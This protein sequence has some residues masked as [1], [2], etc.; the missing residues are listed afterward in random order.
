[1]NR[2]TPFR[3]LA[4]VVVLLLMAVLL[5]SQ[6][7]W[8][9]PQE[10]VPSVSVQ[11][12]DVICD[13]QD[14]SC[15]SK[16]ESSGA[17][18]WGYVP[19]G[20]V[21]SSGAYNL[22]AYWTYNGLNS[23]IDWGLWTPNLPQTGTYDVYIWYPHYPGIVP[24]TNSAR[25]QVHDTGG[26]QAIT[27]NQA[28]N[29]GQWNKIA[30]VNCTAGTGCFVKLTDATSESTSTR[31]VWFDAVKFVLT[32]TPVYSITGVVRDS[33]GTGISDV[34]I[35]DGTR[36]ATTDSSGS[37]TL[38][39]VPVGNYTL[40]PM[41][42][43]Y[44]FSPITLNVTVASAVSGQNFTGT[45]LP[46]SSDT[47]PPDGSITAPL[48]GQT[49]DTSALTFSAVASD[50]PGGSGVARVQF[51]VYYNG[52]WHNVGSATTSPY[53]VRWTPPVGLA[54]QQLQFAIHVFDH[55]GNQRI[56]PG[57]IRL[58]N[59][60]AN[61]A[62]DNG[63]KLPYP[64][65]A[66]WLCTQGNN[67]N[68]SH[69]GQWAYAFDF[70]TPRGSDV[71]ASRNG[72][73]IYV[74]GDSTRGGCSESY[75]NDAN[76]I[77]I[78]H[79]DGTDT[80]YVHLDSVFVRNG[81]TVQRGQ[82]IGR[83]GQ[84][85]YTC[86]N[87]GGP[88]PHLHFDRR[89]TGR[90]STIAT[91]FLDVVGGVP[92]AG[93]WYTSGN[94]VGLASDSV[95]PIGEVRFR[96]TGSTPYTISLLAEDDTTPLNALEMRLAESEAGLASATWQPF[97]SET[98]WDK[99][100]VWV[101]Y[102][103]GAGNTSASYAD[104]LDPVA[105]SAVTAAFTTESSVCENAELS[106]TNQTTPFA[107]QY[108]WNWD[109]DNG[110]ASVASEVAPVTYSAGTHTITLQVTGASNSS[111][112][113]HQ[114]TVLPA[115]NADFTLARDGNTVTVTSNNTSATSWVWDF[116]DGATATGSTATHT[117]ASIPTGVTAPVVH[118]TVQSANGC[119]G[120]ASAIVSTSTAY[121]PMITR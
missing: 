87:D 52:V 4:S 1:M 117:Y 44:S 83:S 10:S 40:T 27:W 26:D 22:H 88:G 63:F 111:T 18:S 50:N 114:V 24:E 78:R 106:I 42:S 74:K 28:V 9:N 84:T 48:H 43:G 19:A 85:G 73:V 49:I 91:S 72:Q 25:Y 51:N 56:D 39:T 101:Q 35:S 23:A 103:D 41:K 92:Y 36:S 55:A 53:Y 98:T 109:L 14:T 95:A 21:G 11:S 76:F 45:L 31:R 118:L 119:A 5:G 86:N 13:N 57:G 100:T 107:A 71:V 70:G 75:I 116:G 6:T 20:G 3:S 77:R 32:A 37:Y 38:S 15:F 79:L 90:S 17:G 30:T 64:G 16:Y 58:V 120:K 8:A 104:T 46:P 102:R 2:S 68:F 59:F 69:Q 66:R 89:N 97:T 105:T 93:G 99:T 82:V 115:P 112:A 67:S 113:T 47:T 29:Y 33:S 65:G 7:S 60:K 96:L 61:P 94:Y 121:L 81:E 12:T 108:Q 34:T 62:V 80:L 54:S 110:V